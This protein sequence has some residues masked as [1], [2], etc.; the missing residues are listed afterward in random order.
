MQAFKTVQ[1]PYRATYN[2]I[3]LLETFRDMVNYCISVGIE[4]GVSS[5]FK[6]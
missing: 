5:K 3:S 1:V 2:A 4:K 6:L